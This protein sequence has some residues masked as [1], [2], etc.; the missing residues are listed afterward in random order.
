M[1]TLSV[2]SLLLLSGCTNLNESKLNNLGC[3]EPRD[4]FEITSS[5]AGVEVGVVSEGIK[6]GASAGIETTN[7]VRRI[8]SEKEDLDRLDGLLFSLCNQ[9]KSGLITLDD[10]R[11]KNERAY[12]EVLGQ[13]KK[14]ETYSEMLN[15]I[16]LEEI[17]AKNKVDFK[18]SKISSSTWYDLNNVNKGKYLNATVIVDRLDV[19]VSNT[20]VRYGKDIIPATMFSPYLNNVK[21]QP[22]EPT[23]Y[24][25]IKFSDIDSFFSTIKPNYKF[26]DASFEDIY[27]PKGYA[28][29]RLT[30]EV[31]Y[32]NPFTLTDY[33]IE[34][35]MYANFKL[36][37]AHEK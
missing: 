12:N 19:S 26:M 5:S 35:S 31:K 22:D 14:L 2:I 27:Q 17:K 25:F 3:I 23:R 34:R 13:K 37:D 4:E 15:K 18:L 7:N 29:A 24:P 32:Y 30:I 8:R 16:K 11:E 10:Y 33:S 21:V 6:N 20:I 28:T 9:Y 36:I 1:K